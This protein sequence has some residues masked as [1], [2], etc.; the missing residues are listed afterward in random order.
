MKNIRPTWIALGLALLHLILS[1]VYAKITPYRQAGT[2]RYLH[3]LQVPDIGAPDERQHA[4]YVQSLLDGHLPVFRPNSAEMGEH[5]EDHQPPLF[6]ALDA[7]WAKLVGVSSVE[8]P[9]GVRLRYLNCLVGAGTVLGVYFLVWW[10]YRRSDIALAAAAIAAVLPMNCALSG[11]ISNDPLLFLLC[12]WTLALLAR[13]LN[14][15][16]TL[17]R[18]V[19]VGL[20]TGLALLTKTTAIALLPILLLAVLIK[21]ENRPSA[22]QI[23]GAAIPLV[24]L[25]LPWLM[26]NQALYGDP[27]AMGAF[28]K[29]FTG[30]AQAD[31]FVQISG[32]LG[33]WISWVGWWAGRSFIGV[34]GYMDIWLNSSGLPYANPA[35]PDPN[36]LYRISLAIMLITGLAWLFSF[37]QQEWKP[38]SAVQ[39]MLL[40]FVILI[41]LSFLSF[42][43]QYFQGQGRY[44][45]PAIGSITVAIVVGAHVLLRERAKF[46]TW[47][48]AILLFL[49]NL[50]AIS[51]LPHEFA[52]RM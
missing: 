2:I 50:Y 13:A 5:Y 1:L 6:Y 38:S 32:P 17:R 33:Y 52:L 42:N 47:G 43:M 40:L 11:A 10:G 16:W 46:L 20:L 15:T 45:Y 19:E 22:A 41:K 14:E 9:A 37:R 7:G 34:F 51:I 39:W 24:L 8:Q 25:A 4:N 21:R 44:L 49:A 29:A 18:A 30:T 28:K 12:T 36:L 3:N 31:A 35:H 23:V 26:R 27:L 48:F